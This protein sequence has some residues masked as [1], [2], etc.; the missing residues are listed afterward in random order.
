MPEAWKIPMADPFIG[1]EEA[2]AVY[3]VVLS[4]WLSAGPRNCTAG[5]RS[6]PSGSARTT[7]CGPS[8]LRR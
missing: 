3:D 5:R 6:K 4:G 1:E 8:F 7:C 2:R